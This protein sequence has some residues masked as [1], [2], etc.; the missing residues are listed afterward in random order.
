MLLTTTILALTLT[1]PQAT[2]ER[3]RATLHATGPLPFLVEIESSPEGSTAY[4]LNGSERIEVPEV[5]RSADGIV[6]RFPH[7]DSVIEVRPEKDLLW[8]GTWT[9]VR[10][11]DRIAEVPI[12]LARGDVRFPAVE[13]TAPLAPRWSVRFESSEVPAVAVF[14][15]PDEHG[16]VE[17]TILTHVGD[18]R[19]L[20][21][22][23]DGER[24]VLSCFDGA[25]AFLFDAR[26]DQDGR[27]AGTFQSGDWWSETFEGTV[28]P[29][30]A[31]P[32]PFTQVRAFAHASLA[33][34]TAIDLDGAERWLG[35]PELTGGPTVVQVFGSWCP[36]CH[37][38]AA[39]LA[40]LQASAAER[41][42]RM[43][44]LAF[45]LGGD[46]ARDLEQV[47]RFRDRHGI[48]F[49]TLLL[50]PANKGHAAEAL[51]VLDAVLSFPTT[52]FVDASGRVHAVH[53][54]FS[55]PAT[56]LEHERLRAEFER[57]VDELAQRAAGAP[58]GL[59]LGIDQWNE[60]GGA[61]RM[62]ELASAPDGWAATWRTDP[63]RAGTVETYVRNGD[64]ITIGTRGLRLDEASQVLID[65]LDVGARLTPRGTTRTPAIWAWGDDPRGILASADTT[66]PRALRELVLA[67][68]PQLAQAGEPGQSALELGLASTSPAVRTATAWA[69]GEG[70]VA[71]SEPFLR[72][73]LASSHAPLR[74][75]AA[76]ALGKLAGITPESLDALRIAASDDWSS[77]REAARVALEA[78][79]TPEPR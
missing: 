10:G 17:G 55:G 3:W 1:G 26:V 63:E 8:T 35:E 20:A 47:R 58:G 22:T 21:G 52:L 75:E 39:Y 65:P 24:L 36:N 60:W 78:H 19:Y 11:P 32:D 67:L 30:A 79:A 71:Q 74:R 37:D 41:G 43:L 72:A 61:G 5:E 73:A 28:D 42:V 53:S 70:R 62:L 15:G 40:E 12:Q 69:V 7:Y 33:D 14:D 57:L 23:W 2:L 56:G 50:G 6:L 77:V 13:R 59:P 16:I 76:R 18:Y 44:G 48:E 27:L 9:K 4:L 45:E 68:V 66:D 54:G 49:P 64:A 25:H 38:E 46:L 34:L 29:N 51:G 31:L